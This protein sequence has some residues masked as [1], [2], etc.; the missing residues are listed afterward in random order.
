M[1]GEAL[2]AAQSEDRRPLLSRAVHD[3][4]ALRRRDTEWLAA[5]WETAQILVVEEDYA[6]PIVETAQ[7]PRLQ[8]RS[9]STVD[10]VDS[11]F[12]LGEYDGTAYVAARGSRDLRADRWLELREVGAD[13]PEVEAGLLVEA[14]ALA[15]WHDRHLF[16]P[17][18]G[19]STDV[20]QA[21]W[22]RRCSD[23]HDQF[24]R[25]DPAVI[26]LVHDGADR[27]IL[28][29]QAVW[30]AGRFSILAGFVEPGESAEEAVAREVSE[31]VGVA[32][33]DVRYTG[34]QPWPFPGSLMLGY[35]AQVIGDPTLRI[36]HDEIAEAHWLT[37]AEVAEQS[38]HRRLPP[39]V[40]I[41]HRIITD[42]LD[43]VLP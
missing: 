24:P 35:T 30:P 23:G 12:F 32:V 37:K 25:T 14:V 36:D 41:A 13:L 15:Q 31:E 33:T 38:A 6:V 28:G 26:M 20:E 3:R 1:T 7:G 21:G 8:W 29:R 27:C 4:A 40:S 5:A 42:W 19:R 34:S 22:V 39:P 18:C 2:P 11:S 43:G 17:R 9:P 10:A 16:C